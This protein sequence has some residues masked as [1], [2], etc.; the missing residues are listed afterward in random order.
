MQKQSCNGAIVTYLGI[1]REFVQHNM[2]AEYG[3]I[4]TGISL[5]IA[6]T[7]T[8]RYNETFFCIGEQLKWYNVFWFLNSLL[9]VT[10]KKKFS[11]FDLL[12]MGLNLNGF[13]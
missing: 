6:E 4:L 5:K 13:F 12:T 1:V 9:R 3:F 11:F 10:Q 7:Y 8:G 2:S